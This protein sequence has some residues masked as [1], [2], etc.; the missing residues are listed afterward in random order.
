MLGHSHQEVL[1]QVQLAVV[2]HHARKPELQGR[3]RFGI[4]LLLDATHI[5]IRPDGPT[6]MSVRR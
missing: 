1:G 5:M 2:L 3:Q 4:S 6:G